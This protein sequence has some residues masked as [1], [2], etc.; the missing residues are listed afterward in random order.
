MRPDG[1]GDHKAYRLRQEEDAGGAG[2][3]E[4]RNPIAQIEKH[5]RRKPGFRQSQENAREIEAVRA[6]A[7][8]VA[9]EAMPHVIMI[10]L[11]QIRAPNF[12]IMPLVN[13]ATQLS[14]AR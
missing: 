13:A 5:A 8:A 3:V 1:S 10:R 4:R 14:S 6:D 9:P 2:A 7:G 12:A 11:S